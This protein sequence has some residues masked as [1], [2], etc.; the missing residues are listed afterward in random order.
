MRFHAFTPKQFDAIP[1]LQ[2]LPA[3]DRFAMQVVST[4][5]PCKVNSYVIEELIDWDNI[6]DDPIFQM[7]FPQQG[8][9]A[10]GHFATMADLLRSGADSATIQRAA[11]A[12]RLE[13][14]PHPAAQQT[15]NVPRLDGEPLPGL[16]H[17][18]RETV[19]FFPRR[20]QTCH[21]YCTFCF[22]WP[23]FVHEAELR[24][25]ASETS[26]LQRY[27]KA[28]R[29]VTD[30]LLTGGDPLI[31]PTA[32]LQ[33]I[34]E[35]LLA[36]EFDHVQTLRIGSKALSYWPFRFTE[37]RDADDLLRLFERLSR[38]G[39]HVALMGHLCHERELKPPMVRKA[40]RRIQDSGVTVR[41]QSPIIAHINDDAEIW[42]TLW[43]EQVKLGII[44]YYCFVARDTGSRRYFEV[45]LVRCW[46]IYRK[47]WQQVSGLARTVRGPSMST[48]PGKIEVQGVAEIGGESVFV[49]RF[50]QGRNPDW[51]QRPF[52]ALFDSKATWLDDLQPAFGAERF[53]YEE[54]YAAMQQRALQGH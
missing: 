9:L 44:P 24:I 26:G 36:P 41:S 47:A 12:I 38:A 4:V 53:F 46:Q 29:D 16:Q 30:L 52:F 6:P 28:R 10:P 18:Y 23:Q 22:R 33:E 31:L 35:P 39:K 37:D 45:P 15:L 3:E 14:N 25:G 54:E 17:K 43:R 7:V 1:Q 5:L 34:L 19:L 51:V 32:A 48:G 2:K 49:L 21:A 8:M 27:L 40:L 42:A 11:H 13:L 20:G 50:V